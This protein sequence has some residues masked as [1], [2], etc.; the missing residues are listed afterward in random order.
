MDVNHVA[1]LGDEDIGIAERALTWGARIED[2]IRRLGRA[3]A[4]NAPGPKTRTIAVT[5]RDARVGGED[6]KLHG[7]RKPAAPAPCSTGIPFKAV[8][9][10]LDRHLDL[11]DLDRGVLQIRGGGARAVGAVPMRHAAAAADDRVERCDD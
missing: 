5:D 10:E 4:E 7:G 1:G 3:A 2:Q 11:V 8:T 9:K 6:A